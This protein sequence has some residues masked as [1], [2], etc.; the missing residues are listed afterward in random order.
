MGIVDKR[1]KK[2]F[3]DRDGP[4]LMNYRQGIDHMYST[5][6]YHKNL[7]ILQFPE[8]NY[9]EEKVYDLG[10]WRSKEKKG[11]KYREVVTEEVEYEYIG[12]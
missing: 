12:G 11:K 8:K 9:A 10:G 7:K 6:K 3:S 4:E 5:L 1:I 2:Y